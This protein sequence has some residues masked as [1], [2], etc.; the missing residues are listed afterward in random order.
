MSNPF[1][2]NFQDKSTWQEGELGK[3][4][5]LREQS[6]DALP[7][8]ET[9]ELTLELARECAAIESE[10]PRAVRL[11][12]SLRKRDPR[13]RELWQPLV[14][15]LRATGQLEELGELLGEVGTEIEDPAERSQLRLERADLL[16][17]HE[18]PVVCR[19]GRADH[20]GHS[21]A[22]VVQEGEY[23]FA[24]LRRQLVGGRCTS[25]VHEKERADVT[26]LNRQD[27]KNA[28]IHGQKCV[29]M[30]C[31]RTALSI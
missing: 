22:E 23:V 31:E 18:A 13:S 12:Q 2:S 9:R 7:A 3:S 26:F 16:L 25:D 1:D 24:L 5:D 20:E 21:R 11:Y 30:G 10:Q 8:E 19:G 28:K 29:S 14:A 4:L 15:L 6:I 27:A 17:Q